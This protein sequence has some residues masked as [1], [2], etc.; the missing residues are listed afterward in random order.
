MR[1]YLEE[2]K[3]LSRFHSFGFRGHRSM[4]DAY[5]AAR[6]WSLFLQS[7]DDFHVSTDL[8]VESIPALAHKVVMNWD[9]ELQC[10]LEAVRVSNPLLSIPKGIFLF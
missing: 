8:P 9:D 1:K 5:W 6:A 2:K 4:E 10:H 3:K 7:S